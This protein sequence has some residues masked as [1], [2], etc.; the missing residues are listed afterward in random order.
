MEV[1]VKSFS[2]YRTIK[3]A[4]MMTSALVLDS[5]DAD[6]SN[7]VVKGTGIG[8]TDAGNW[9]IVDGNVF[10]I[11][12]VKPERDRTSLTLLS[13]LDAFSRAIATDE[14]PAEQSIGAFIAEQLKN[15]WIQC[16]DPSYATPYLTVSNSDT[17][18]YIPPGLDNAGTFFLPDY[19]RLMRR[20]YR[21][22]ASFADAGKH[23]QCKIGRVP[24]AYHQVSFDDGRSQLE[25]VDYSFSGAAKIT[26]RCETSAGTACTDWYLAEDGSVSEDIPSRRSTG[27]WLTI[28]AKES[29]DIRAKVIETFAKNKTSHKLEFWSV[30]DLAV[31][32]TCTFQVYGELMQSHISYKRKT[33]EDKRI[34]YKSGEL[35]TTATEKLRG[36]LK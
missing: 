32:D 31:Q 30:L 7:L 35:A 5:L 33:S 13:P 3:Q 29:D 4:T 17:S 20:S 27:S 11:S 14:Q 16:D 18:P 15:N 6:T 2:T 1:F 28:A 26:V 36:V 34:Y 19:A 25:S 24:E 9:L 8:R 21:V 22:R 12:A 23:L 10:L